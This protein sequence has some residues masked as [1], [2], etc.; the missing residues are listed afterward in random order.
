VLDSAALEK[1]G[2]HTVTI[3]W[4]TFERAARMAARVQKVPDMLLAVIPHRKGTDTPEDQRAKARA[5]APEVVRLL[6]AS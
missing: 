3:A 4:D 1:R 5:I 6:L 2:I